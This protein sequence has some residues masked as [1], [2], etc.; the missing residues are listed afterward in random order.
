MRNQSRKTFVKVNVIQ[1]AQAVQAQKDRLKRDEFIGEIK[2]ARIEV[3][4]AMETEYPPTKPENAA[5]RRMFDLSAN[6]P[7]NAVKRTSA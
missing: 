7:C 5:V 1:G 2:H 3:Q 6:R 4:Y